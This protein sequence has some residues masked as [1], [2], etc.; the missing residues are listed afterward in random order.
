MIHV[1]YHA[2]D[3]FMDILNCKNADIAKQ[4]L[5]EMYYNSKEVKISPYISAQRILRSKIRNGGE[6][7]ETKYFEFECY[8]MAVVDGVIITFEK[9]FKNRKVRPPRQP[10]RRTNQTNRKSNQ[11]DKRGER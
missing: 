2:V 10:R 8:R 9:K 3:K 11:S 4:R 6:I 7:K 5:I 1:T